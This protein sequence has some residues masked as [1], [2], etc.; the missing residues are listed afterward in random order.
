MFV[1]GQEEAGL[2]FVC[3]VL[4]ARSCLQREREQFLF[5]F[6]L[7]LFLSLSPFLS[8]PQQ[9][10]LATCFSLSFPHPLLSFLFS[11]ISPHVAFISF[12]P[13]SCQQ[14]FFPSEDPT[15]LTCAQLTPFINVRTQLVTTCVRKTCRH[16]HLSFFQRMYLYQTYAFHFYIVK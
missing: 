14:Y 9:L 3:E 11:L 2:L 6:A 1:V 15:S 4:T 5:H 13:W 12:A 10:E 7:F 16:M 8:G